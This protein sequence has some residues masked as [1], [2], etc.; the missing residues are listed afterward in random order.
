MGGLTFNLQKYIGQPD[1]S[2]EISSLHGGARGIHPHKN[3]LTPKKC[4]RPGRMWI[5]DRGVRACRIWANTL[6]S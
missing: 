6:R 2:R 1:H 3:P 5:L 4:L